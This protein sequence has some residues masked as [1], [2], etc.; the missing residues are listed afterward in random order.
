MFSFSGI[1]KGNI[2]H[3]SQVLNFCFFV[4]E[5]LSFSIPHSSLAFKKSVCIFSIFLLEKRNMSLIFFCLAEKKFSSY[6]VHMKVHFISSLFPLSFFLQ[7]IL[8]SAHCLCCIAIA[9]LE[10]SGSAQMWLSASSS[11]IRMQLFSFWR[12]RLE[13][14]KLHLQD[15]PQSMKTAGKY[16][17]KFFIKFLFL[18]Y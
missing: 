17:C 13:E 10:Q 1:K 9:Q 18:L 6:L 3:V 4:V 7:V 8:S 14:W 16:P 15:H 5:K 11:S 2:I 12:T